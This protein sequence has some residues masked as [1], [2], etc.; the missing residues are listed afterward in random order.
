MRLALANATHKWGGVKSWSLDVAAGLLARGHEILVLARQGEFL[1]R[2][3]ALGCQTVALNFGPD[4]NPRAILQA[5]AELRAFRAQV[6]IGNV[7]K[8]LRTVG[9]AARLLGI[10]VVHR[11]GLAGDVRPGLAAWLDAWLL[12]PHLLAPC[13]HVLHGV[14]Q[15]PAMQRL[16]GTVIRT[17]KVPGPRPSRGQSP[18]LRIVSASQL[19]PDKDHATAL[20][21]LATLRR[22]GIAFHYDVLGTGPLAP[23]LPQL[24][25]DLGLQECV[26]WHGFVADVPAQL[27][28]ADILLLPSRS[29]GLPNALL[30]AM[31]A[32]LAAVA[33]NVGGIA[34]I[35]PK[36]A[37]WL[38]LAPDA[39]AEAFA[40][41]LR[42]LAGLCP[43]DFCALRQ[44]FWQALPSR[45]TMLDALEA[46]L[47]DHRGVL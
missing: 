22:D 26:T 40:A 1:H 8:D 14:R 45:E 37:P 35:W 20:H 12:R 29:E 13:E 25:Q 30:E 16:A 32:G 3:K 38:L 28:Q 43:E 24:A 5:A 41:A 10:P 31:A 2:A 42:R 9:L 46:F 27:A 4:Y 44:A 23:T 47:L 6:V 36:S 21:A 33:R 15:N 17:G 18:C 11:V 19:T 39:P 34:E 7:G